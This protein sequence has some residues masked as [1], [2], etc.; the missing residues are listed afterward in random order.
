MATPPP[1]YNCDS[2][3]VGIPEDLLSG[4]FIYYVPTNGGI[5]EH[6]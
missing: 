4:M 5:I 1:S 2:E 6:L 3:D